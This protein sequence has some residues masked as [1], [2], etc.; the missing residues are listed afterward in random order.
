MVGELRGRFLLDMHATN[1]HRGRVD[2]PL[3][4]EPNTVMRAHVTRLVIV[5]TYHHTYQHQSLSIVVSSDH[6]RSLLTLI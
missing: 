6:I 5:I 4:K 1:S 2:L 3:L